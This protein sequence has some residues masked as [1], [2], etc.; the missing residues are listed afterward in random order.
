MG[1]P[2]CRAWVANRALSF[3]W[4]AE[5]FPGNRYLS[6]RSE[7]GGRIERIGKKYQRIAMMELLARL[8]DNFWIK[9]QWDSG[10]AVCGWWERRRAAPHQETHMAWTPKLND[11]QLILLATAAQRADGSVLPP[12]ET[13]VDQAARIR[14]ALPPLIKRALVREA[15]VLE[16]S[17]A[18]RSDG[19]QQVGVFITDAGR[20]IIGTDAA[21]DVE[22]AATATP[23]ID[24]LLV[25]VAEPSPTAP[26]SKIARVKAL[27]GRDAGATLDK[28]VAATGWLPHTTRAA[29]TG[30]RKKG[31][32]LTRSKRG[33]AT[34]YRIERAA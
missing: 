4:T 34:C 6:G 27:L 10:A 12:P 8:A 30:L 31:H 23:A 22:M 29:L 25:A 26:E 5:R 7:Q 17:R 24:A 11:L 3:G 2:R 14:R 15:D 32:A 16:A 9:P 13:V 21:D 18:W 28:L 20:T 1:L 19:E 33:D